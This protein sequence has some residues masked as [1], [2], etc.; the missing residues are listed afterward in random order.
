[1][2]TEKEYSTMK[3]YKIDGSVIIS[4]V[5]ENCLENYASQAYL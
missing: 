3:Y 5:F 2:P 4:D 1:M